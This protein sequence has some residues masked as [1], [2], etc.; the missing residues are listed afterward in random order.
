M[1]SERLLAIAS[2]INKE[3]SLIDV[4]CD[5]GYLGIY[6]KDNNLVNDLLL[7]DVNSNALNNAINNIKNKNLNIE[8]KLTDGIKDID[9]T[10][11]NT[12]SISGMGTPSIKKILKELNDSNN[13]KKIIIQ[14]NNNLKE[15]RMFLN[16]IGYYLKDEITLQENDIWYVISLFE[17]NNL[18]NSSLE[19]AYGLLK[20]DKIKYYQYLINKDEDILKKLPNNKKDKIKEE[21]DIINNL[22]KKCG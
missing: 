22:L 10:I 17:K 13:I 6:L 21:I 14:S 20:K 18:K 9:L 15:L 19:L 3:D 7:T 8:T 16:E 1:K 4:G 11:Y 12:I 2:F 5:H